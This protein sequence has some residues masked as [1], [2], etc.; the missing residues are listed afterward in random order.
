MVTSADSGKHPQTRRGHPERS[1]AKLVVRQVLWH[2]FDYIEDEG[3]VSLYKE[4]VDCLEDELLA[5]GS[6]GLKILEELTNVP[7]QPEAG[8]Y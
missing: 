2:V 3:E 8:D 6:D 7:G 4:I 1:G 5:Q